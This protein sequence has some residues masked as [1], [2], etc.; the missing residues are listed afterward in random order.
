MHRIQTNGLI[1]YPNLILGSVVGKIVC[2][3]LGINISLAKLNT[4]L[5]YY[6]QTFRT[7][8]NPERVKMINLSPGYPPHLWQ[9]NPFNINNLYMGYLEGTVISV[10]LKLNTEEKIN[11]IWHTWTIFENKSEPFDWSCSPLILNP[12]GSVIGLFRF[13]ITG[14]DKC[15]AVSSLKLWQFGYE[16]CNGERLF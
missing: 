7:D 2:S 10:G 5:H 11:Y 3:S 16:I 4:G 9:Y 15:L 6:N 8:A 13:K 12:Q 14:D 1:F